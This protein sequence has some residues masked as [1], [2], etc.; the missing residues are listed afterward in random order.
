MVLSFAQVEIIEHPVI[1]DNS[2][3]PVTKREGMFCKD[4]GPLLQLSWNAN[5]RTTVDVDVYEVTRHRR[6]HGSELR[7]S[8]EKRIQMLHDCRSRDDTPN[9]DTAVH[10]C[11]R[12]TANQCQDHQ[13]IPIRRRDSYQIEI[14]KLSQT[15]YHNCGMRLIV[16]Y[17]CVPR[18]QISGSVHNVS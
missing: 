13:R 9:R 14:A 17:D 5:R 18:F 12:W 3:D 2:Y 7:L 16:K 4:G 10:T 6:R 1:F 11:C 15:K 8:S